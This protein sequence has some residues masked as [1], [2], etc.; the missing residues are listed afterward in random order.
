MR[1]A[2]DQTG[3]HEHAIRVKLYCRVEIQRCVRHCNHEFVIQYGS[4]R[5]GSRIQVQ[6][7]TVVTTFH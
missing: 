7:C 6:P 2:D 4:G 5:A 3:T 1:P